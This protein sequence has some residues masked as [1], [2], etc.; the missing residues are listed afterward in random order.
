LAAASKPNNSRRSVCSV[1]GLPIL[2]VLTLLFVVTFFVY[3]F[4][5]RYW[6]RPDLVL[7]IIG[8]KVLP[9]Q[10]NWSSAMEAVIWSVRIPRAIAVVL[11]GAG[12]A[13]SGTVFQGTFRNPLVSESILGVS[14][15]AGFGAALG[16][17]L[18]QTAYFIELFAFVFALI[19]VGIAY[20]I[21][22]VHRSSPMLLMVLGGIVI[23]SLFSAFTSLIKYLADPQDKLPSIVFWLLGSFANIT[24]DNIYV[25]APGI[26]ICMI[27]LFLLRWR[28]NVLSMGDDEAKALGV[29]AQRLRTVVIVC[30]TVI[31]AGVVCICGLIGWVG[32]IIPQ[33]CRL[34]VGPNHKYLV[35]TSILVGAIFLLFVD[36]ICR[37]VTAGEIPISIIT[38]VVLAPIFLYL[39]TRTK[40]GWM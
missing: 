35:P 7:Q 13:V 5:G 29:D 22:H 3:L 23:G 11:A 1:G 33:M 37:T 32:L 16:I 15:G 9:I 34:L 18:G 20:L 10:N 17:L 24:I 26:I 27:V 19:A 39:L 8:S 40:R 12:L 14:S 4:V 30:A 6:I 2:I 31:T 28:L 25:V 38:S 36:L 21:G